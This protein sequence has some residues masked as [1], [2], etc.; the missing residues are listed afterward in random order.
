MAAGRAIRGHWG[1]KCVVGREEVASRASA[2]VGVKILTSP[3]E[4]G[5][6][7]PIATD[8]MCTVVEWALVLSVNE[9]LELTQVRGFW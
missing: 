4:P 9:I 5:T 3:S 2:A 1:G 6:N 7:V 8:H